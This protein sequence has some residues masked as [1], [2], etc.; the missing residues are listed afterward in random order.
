MKGTI[1]I[2]AGSEVDI[3]ADGSLDY[4]NS[5][6]KELDIV[7]A[8]PHAALTQDAKRA[9]DRLIRAIHNPYV[10][11]I[12]HAT[13]RMVLRREGLTPDMKLVLAAAAERGIA[14][15]INANCHRLDLRDMHAR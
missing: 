5:L 15:E 9:T 3:L 13:G 14:M 6:L 8:S 2:L 10:T 12:G 11:I 1:R 4:P 7:V